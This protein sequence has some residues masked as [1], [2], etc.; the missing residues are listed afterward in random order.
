MPIKAVGRWVHPGAAVVRGIRRWAGWQLEK[1]LPDPGRS[2]Q[3]L[4]LDEAL[5]HG[6]DWPAG[7]RVLDVGCYRGE[8]SRAIADRGGVVVGLDVDEAALVGAGGDGNWRVRGDGQHLPFA[9]AA[10]DTIFC[11]MTANLF[12]A[13]ALA[14]REFARCCAPGGRVILSVCNLRAPYQRVNAALE[15]LWPDCPWA[16]LRTSANRWSARD[17]SEALASAGAPL[18]EIY[19]CNLCWPL[20]HRIRGRWIIPNRLMWR[21]NR[22]VRRR[23]G[24]SLRTDRLHFA[25]HDYVL[26]F[27]RPAGET[28]TALRVHRPA[29]VR[30]GCLT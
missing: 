6:I 30:E 10:F 15:H 25:A 27:R 23:T 21:W 2:F 11:H 1:A 9:D 22:A 26:V 13:P 17:W 24:L 8:Y 28:R 14:A 18:A 5:F 20:V 4:E 16:T 3:R 7:E 29:R 12:P 19:S